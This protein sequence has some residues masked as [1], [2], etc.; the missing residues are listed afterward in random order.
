MHT[1]I[2]EDGIRNLV[3]LFYGKIREDEALGPVFN[4]AIREG[5]WPEHLGK[6]CAFWSSVML[7]TGRYHGNPHQKHMD[8]PPFEPALFDRWLELF[9]E[10]AHEVFTADMA[11]SFQEASR[12]IARSLRYGLYGHP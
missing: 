9:S 6:M 4:R 3:H 12:N 5:D 1:A 2:T 10:T 7:G 8:L 11:I